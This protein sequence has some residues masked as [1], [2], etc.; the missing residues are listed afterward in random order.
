MKAAGLRPRSDDV[1]VGI[2]LAAREHHVVVV[3]AD[4]PQQRCELEHLESGSCT[5]I[6]SRPL[7]GGSP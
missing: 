4:G 2:D 5:I 6:G 7:T 3:D 1:I